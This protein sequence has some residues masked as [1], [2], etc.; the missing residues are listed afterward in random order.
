MRGEI[1][2]N[3]NFS[4]GDPHG[5]RSNRQLS[6]VFFPLIDIARSGLRIFGDA[7]LQPA[8]MRR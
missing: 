7:W 5:H 8:P 1:G 3:L 4:K 2:A 6:I